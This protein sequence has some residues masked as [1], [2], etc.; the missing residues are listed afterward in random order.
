MIYERIIRLAVSREV[1]IVV[2]G[3]SGKLKNHVT[4]ELDFFIKDGSDAFFH[5]L[6]GTNHPQYWK[7]KKYTAEKSQYLQLEYSGVSRNQLNEIIDT[8]RNQHPAG[9]TFSFRADIGKRIKHLK[10]IRVP[11]MTIRMLASA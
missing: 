4:I 6:I 1:K 5:P 2:S 10:G 11:A 7:L 9:Y 3:E 8:F